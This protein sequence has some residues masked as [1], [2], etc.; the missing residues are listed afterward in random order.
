MF[1]RSA[2][3]NLSIDSIRARA[4]GTCSDRNSK[5]TV[6][7]CAWG[8]RRRTWGVGDDAQQYS[9]GV[10]L[11]DPAV[12]VA[13]GDEDLALGG[14]RDRGGHAQVVLAGAGDEALAEREDGGELPGLELGGN[15]LEGRVL[16]GDGL[17]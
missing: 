6:L 4:W 13:V 3:H 17:P 11:Q 7:I 8:R 10:E 14:D 16:G 15:R 1:S 9:R 12:A 5:T 2:T